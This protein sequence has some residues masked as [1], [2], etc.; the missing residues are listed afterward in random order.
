MTTANPTVLVQ[1]IQPEIVALILNR[2]EAA[3]A[4]NMQ[5]AK[6]LAEAFRLIGK[7]PAVRVVVLAGQGEKVFCAG[8]DLKERK[9]MDELAWHKQHAAFESALEAII[10][11]PLPVI[12][13][14]NG[15]AFGGGLELAMAC[16][17]IYAVEHAKLALTEVTLGIMPG[18]GGATQLARAVGQARAK[19]LLYSGT[20]FSAQE[21]YDWGLVNKVCT[22]ATLFP[23]T[24]AIAQKMVEGAPL[25]V[26]AIKQSLR[27][28][29][30]L[31][32]SD[33]LTAELK[34]YNRL[35]GSKDRHEGINA[36]NEKRKPN[37][38][39]E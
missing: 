33:A 26:Q 24:M 13:A 7:D 39:G 4:L 12:A 8:A 5:M 18:L 14:V 20:A 31:S 32:L 38:T 21:A 30:S 3:N 9:G 19:E 1:K 6:E 36:F 34:Y 22:G 10:G 17:F 16:D 37:F 28:T 2:P 15:A 27:Q 35:L 23:E 29:M 11:C 25:A